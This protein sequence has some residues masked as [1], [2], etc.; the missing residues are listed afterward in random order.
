MPHSY[1]RKLRVADLLK[2]ELANLLLTHSNDPRFTFVSITGIEI[3]KDYSHAKV[4]V[5][6][7]NENKTEEV[8]NALNKAA[9]FFRH[10]LANNVNLRTT[11]KLHF[12][13]DETV[14]KGQKIS[15]LLA[16]VSTKSDKE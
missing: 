10:Q 2:Q 11:P 6:I 12:H 7:L 4:F 1:D 13:Y 3:S 5:T 8:I 15:Q 16:K 14:C 9:G